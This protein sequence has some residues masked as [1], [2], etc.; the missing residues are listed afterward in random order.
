[1]RGGN[2]EEEKRK[3]C[4]WREDCGRAGRKIKCDGISPEKGNYLKAFYWIYK[5]RGRWGKKLFSSRPVKKGMLKGQKIGNLI[6]AA[7]PR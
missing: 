4:N 1:M 3:Q 7:L 6:P 2:R 5:Q